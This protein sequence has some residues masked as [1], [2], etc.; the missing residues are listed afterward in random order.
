M[1]AAKIAAYTHNTHA[2]TSSW[3]HGLVKGLTIK[4]CIFWIDN[5]FTKVIL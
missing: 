1:N 3:I 2:P 4:L 5:D